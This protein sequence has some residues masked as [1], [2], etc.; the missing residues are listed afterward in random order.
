MLRLLPR[1]CDEPPCTL[2]E[3][4]IPAQLARLLDARG[5]RT[6][7]EAEAFLHPSTANLHDPMLLHDMS[8][9]TERIRRALEMQECI[10]VYGDYDVDGVCA[11]ALLVEALRA[12]GAQADWYIP[13]RHKE[14]Y[15][16]NPQAVRTLAERCSLLI[17]VDCG[18]TSIEEAILA[19][20]LGLDMVITDHHEP[21]SRLP[22]ALAVVDPLLGD[23]PFRRLCGA[24]V[25]LKLVWA[26][27]G[28]EAV[29]N[30]WEL[31][32]LATVAD[33]VPLLGENRI[34]VH[35]GLKRMQK[36][37]RA[38]IKALLQV[39][40]LSGKT[41]TAGHLGFQIGPRINAGGRLHEASRNVELLLTKEEDAAEA[42]ACALQEEN[43]RRQRMEADILCQ[44]DAWVQDH[45]DFLTERAIIVVGRD[46]NPG[47][48]GLVA[49]RLVERYAWPALVLSENEEG[50][51]TGSAR[52]IPGV[53]LHAALT[54]CEHL[55]IRFGGH[56]Q[57]AGMTL[58]AEQLPA[59]REML[60]KAIDEVAEKDAFIPSVYYDM[61]ISL[62]EVTVELIRQFER[63][64]PTGLGNPAPTFRLHGAQV[65]EARAVGAEGKHL[66]LRL[67]QNGTALDGIAFGQGSARAG[68][69]QQVD[70]LFS[71]GI[72]EYMGRVSAQ[73]EVARLL[74]H[75]AAASFIAACGARAD[76]FDCYL[77]NTPPP[78]AEPISDEVLQA[79]VLEALLSSC[80]GTLLTV[81][82]ITG[83]RRWAQW[84]QDNGLSDHVDFCFDSAQDMRRFNT[85]CA[86]PGMSAGEGFTRVYALDDPLRRLAVRDWLPSDD[87][88]RHL[89]RILRDGQGRFASER[90]V[91]EAAGMRA[92][93]VRL[94]L[95]VFEELAL[96][97]Y[98]SVPF[99]AALLAP[100]KTSLDTSETLRRIRDAYPQEGNV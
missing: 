36:T 93:A 81:S 30:L 95:R 55:F 70:V 94:G 50:V 77:L 18:I 33:L 51:V 76:D 24:G 19:N 29:S 3:A 2:I 4:G 1:L 87:A 16:L 45:V 97:A 84:L 28:E 83:A 79:L 43:T 21:S 41:I 37:S 78:E 46:W 14:G 58:R 8:A 31:A 49:S 80:Q 96:V 10:V 42:I 100:K 69:A 13:S 73:C 27:F 6:A 20:S 47:V 62:G 22:Q 68:L 35:E 98:R 26:L 52:S 23:Y 89:Y 25:A 61:D 63:L 60:S 86:M 7:A 11:S 54:R 71:P 64:A 65:L 92:A 90:A 44:A 72:N 57:A 82:T 32:A 5:V 39:A 75:A 34:I 9:A 48:V 91:A 88:L 15:G 53:N 40:G 85:L 12:H 74:P 38:G 59:L 17:T 99:S 66:K 67:E 56:A